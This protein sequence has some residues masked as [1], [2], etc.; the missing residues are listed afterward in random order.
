MS[1]VLDSNVLVLNRYYQP[2][3]VTSVRQAFSLLYQG[4]A[5][6]VDGQYRTFDFD[7][8]SDLSAQHGDDVVHT[9]SRVI[10]VPRVIILQV[11]DRLPRPR[12]R[13]SRQNIYL[14]DNCTCQYC[15]QKKPRPQLNLDHVMP[16][17]RGGRTSWENIVCS[18]VK[19]NFKKGG[20]TP[21]EAGMRLLRPP[22]RPRWSPFTRPDGGHRP[23]AAW[24]PFLSMVDAAYWNTELLDD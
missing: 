6:A 10:V 11:F 13:F 18:C 20:R 8:W 22:T 23:H 16:K 5:C 1:D 4:V 9:V 7:S 24:K 3:N 2:V 21:A 15:G 12:V 14:R 19:C 17:S